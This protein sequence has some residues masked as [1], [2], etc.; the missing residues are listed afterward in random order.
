MHN[1][2]NVG[3]GI[4]TLILA[5]L[6]SQVLEKACEHL[7]KKPIVHRM[8]PKAMARQQVKFPCGPEVAMCLVSDLRGNSEQLAFS[9]SGLHNL[10][11]ESINLHGEAL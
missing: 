11:S 10:S 9:L 7:G 4:S 3:T 5:M 2:T 6:H 8:N 1:D